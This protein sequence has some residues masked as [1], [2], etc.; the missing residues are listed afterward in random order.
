MPD[1]PAVTATMLV[2]LDR[3]SVTGVAARWLLHELRNPLQAIGLIPEL[4]ALDPDSPLD[5]PLRTMLGD[6]VRQLGITLELFD[7]VLRSPAHD[8]EPGPVA[9]GDALA[10]AERLVSTRRASGEVSWAYDAAALPAVLAVTPHLVHVVLSLIL[11]GLEAGGDT[12]N[13]WVAARGVP[14]AGLE[15]RVEDDGPGVAPEIEA[16]LF[17]PLVTTKEGEPCR[18]LGL[19]AARQLLRAVDGTVT[20]EG[21]ADGRTKF[22]VSLREWS[23]GDE[24]A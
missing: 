2:A 20:Y 8:P 16:R 13:V 3:A 1:G 4:A 6:G 9:P 18:G 24:G 15:I 23:A 5:E 19:F 12:A 17:E 22:V 7:D 11:N 21:R 10:R 14:G